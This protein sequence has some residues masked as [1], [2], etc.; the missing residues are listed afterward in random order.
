VKPYLGVWYQWA[1]IPNRF[2]QQCVSDTTASYRSLPDDTIE[3]LNRCRLA[4]GR[5]DEALGQARPVAGVSR[6]AE[7]VLQPAQLQVSFL[8][9]WLRWTGI[10]WGA[11]WVIDRPEHGRYAV[12]SEPSRQ[13]LWVLSRN[14]TLSGDD[15]QA[16]QRTV[17]SAG[18]DWQRVQRHPHR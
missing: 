12:V 15:E 2:Q 13:Y 18:F 7:G 8:P 5:W 17:Q 9:T 3:V 11:Y 6:I 16:V 1:F 4:D 14:S 10:G